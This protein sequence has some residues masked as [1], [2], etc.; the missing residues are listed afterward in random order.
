[1]P[2]QPAPPPASAEAE[3]VVWG[4]HSYVAN[5]QLF[6][7][8]KLIAIGWHEVGD[9]GKL[10]PSRLA[11]KQRLSQVY[12]ERQ[13]AA[14]ATY[15]GQIY[16][17]VHEVK[18]GDL[19]VYPSK[20][21]R[22]IHIGRIAGPYR[23]DPKLSEHFPHVRAVAWI[24]SRPR[25]HFSQGALY[26]VG[27][28][29]TLFQLRNYADEFRAAAEGKSGVPIVPVAQDRTVDDVTRDIEDT[30]ADFIL[31]TLAQETKGHRF[32]E[33][34]EHLLNTMDYRTRRSA[35][36]PD[37]GVDIVAHRDE[38]GFEPPIVKV[39]VKSTEGSVGDPV[40]S[41][42]YGK[43]GTGEYGPLVTLGSFTRQARTF[44]QS[45]TNLRLI[46]GD[47]LVKLVLAH[48]DQFDA[49]YKS[50]IPLKRVHVPDRAAQDD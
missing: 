48:Y 41:A 11:V 5:D 30:T 7:Q 2:K 44:A 45:K 20:A 9:L 43:V 35:E 23:H 31:K 42:L 34:V 8:R 19:V 6:L 39:Q 40:V 17:F 29:L 22:Q 46:D 1:M 4:I 37:G 13:S 47:D 26:E 28:A 12:P 49:K 21:D 38:L 36:G 50:L 32:A 15:A 27:S 3:T 16:R 18:E 24:T 10:E 25:T 33:F 14:I